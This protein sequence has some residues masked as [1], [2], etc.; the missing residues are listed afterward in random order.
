MRNFLTLLFF[1]GCFSI[2]F[3]DISV[4]SFRKLENDLD[5]RVH[6]PLTDQN[7][8]VCAIIKVVTTQTGFLFDGGS[9][10]IVKTVQKPAEIWVYVPWGL[11]RLT[12]THPQL[13]LLRDYMIPVSIEKATVYEL[14]LVNKLYR[15]LRL[16]PN[17]I[18]W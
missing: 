15:L 16:E 18:A 5:A 10:G 7:G 12:I 6:N 17:A 1:V 11:K 14:V 8:E 13:G 2:L 4:K 3:A 9:M